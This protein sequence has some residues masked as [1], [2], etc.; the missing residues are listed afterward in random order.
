MARDYDDRP[1]DCQ[2]ELVAGK[3]LLSFWEGTGC[4]SEYEHVYEVR[5]EVGSDAMALGDSSGAEF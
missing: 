5:G 4:E 1:P 2:Q 3:S